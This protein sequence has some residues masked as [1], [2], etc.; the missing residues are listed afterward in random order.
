MTTKTVEIEVDESNGEIVKVYT[1]QEN[2]WWSVDYYLTPII[3]DALVQFRENHEH[4]VPYEFTV[5]EN[6]KE[7]DFNQAEINWHSTI[8]K[9]INAFRLMQ[10]DNDG[11]IPEYYDRVDYKYDEELYKNQQL[12]I[13]E[14]L[15]LFAKYFRGLWD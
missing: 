1:L 4:G 7:I 2:H 11:K 14:G 13:E 15:L 12:Q 8:D 10:L 3:L 5:D 9:M 6:G